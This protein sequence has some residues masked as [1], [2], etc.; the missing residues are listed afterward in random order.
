M[1]IQF[2]VSLVN[3]HL[4]LL[5]VSVTFLLCASAIPGP[6]DLDWPRGVRGPKVQVS[7]AWLEKFSSEFGD[8]M[9]DSDRIHLPSS[10]SRKDIYDRMCAELTEA[11]DKPSSLT[12]FLYLWRT[13]HKNISIPKVCLCYYVGNN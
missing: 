9:P 8:K 11:G 7:M 5:I 2:R 12:R 10:M 4:R 3:P 6:Q 13:D 1:S